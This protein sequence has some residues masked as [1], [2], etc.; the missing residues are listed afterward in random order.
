M[1][2]MAEIN[3]FI[4]DSNQLLLI[5]KRSSNT[6]EWDMYDNKRN[7]F[8]SVTKAL[9]PNSSDSE[10]TYSGLFTIF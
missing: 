6:S 4:Q 10:A 3:L 2:V 7:T 8:N 1:L 9:K 5:E